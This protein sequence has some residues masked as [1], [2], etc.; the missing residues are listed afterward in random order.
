MGER[1]KEWGGGRTDGRPAGRPA[2]NV[3]VDFV[4]G[5]CVAERG[6]VSLL[7]WC[8]ALL[9]CSAQRR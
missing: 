2:A 3:L 5:A 4:V 1:P 8:D 7:D 6:M 9:P